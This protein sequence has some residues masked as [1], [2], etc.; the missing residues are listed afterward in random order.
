MTLQF[1][2]L[3]I[4][5]QGLAATINSS[6]GPNVGKRMQKEEAKS[7]PPTAS[8][9]PASPLGYLN[10][11]SGW[12]SRERGERGRKKES[13]SR[14][15]PHEALITRSQLQSLGHGS[16]P[17]HFGFSAG[18][19]GVSPRRAIDH[20]S[21]GVA[22]VVAVVGV[23][24]GVGLAADSQMGCTQ[25]R[26]ALPERPRGVN[27]LRVR[28]VADGAI[29][30]GYVSVLSFPPHDR[31]WECG[32]SGLGIPQM[33][34]SWR[35]RRTD[36]MFLGG[37]II[38]GIDRG[39]HPLGMMTFSLATWQAVTYWT[40]TQLQRVILVGKTE[41]HNNPYP[42]RLVVHRPTWIGNLDTLTQMVQPCQAHLSN[43]HENNQTSQSGLFFF[44]CALEISQVEAIRLGAD[45][46][47]LWKVSLQANEY[48]LL[49]TT[50]RVR[51][52]LP[53]SSKV[54]PRAWKGA[55]PFSSHRI[56]WC[57]LN[58]LVPCDLARQ[59]ERIQ[60]LAL[61]N[62]R[63]GDHHMMTGLSTPR[64][65]LYTL[66][67]NALVRAGLPSLDYTKQNGTQGK[68]QQAQKPT[69]EPIYCPPPEVEH[70]DH[71]G[72]L[73]LC[74]ASMAWALTFPG[75]ESDFHRLHVDPDMFR[76]TLT[77]P[78]QDL[79]LARIQ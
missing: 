28:P 7:V 73:V 47:P 75:S 53:E 40:L 24:V 11:P 37:G 48:I 57:L 52:I 51:R 79:G 29:R 62:A 19:T 44:R 60:A 1:L 33:S 69:S 3:V 74:P 16:K 61:R 63:D 12:T 32:L 49:G 35:S 42:A 56:S 5:T 4:S 76:L 68:G 46:V 26:V 22:A 13:A 6:S 34:T 43:Q 15:R 70:T 30:H 21:L 66:W 59:E 64:T 72:F 20:A 50:S 71:P 58:Y 39:S 38:E 18:R 9:T 25:I 41:K 23:G 77:P 31:T 65:L 54:S 36:Y 78:G 17:L 8:E 67:V 45:P 55:A 2:Q 27:D 14:M 10:H